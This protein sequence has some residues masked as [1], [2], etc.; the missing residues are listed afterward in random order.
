MEL[1]IGLLPAKH[2]SRGT[3]VIVLPGPGAKE[4]LS[5]SDVHLMM[6]EIDGET[7]N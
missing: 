7:A 5:E 4:M 1:E 3:V 6:R 2:E